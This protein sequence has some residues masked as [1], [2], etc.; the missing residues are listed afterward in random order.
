[1][2]NMMATVVVCDG[3]T[4]SLVISKALRKADSFVVLSLSKYETA[5]FEVIKFCNHEIF[6]KLNKNI[7]KIILVLKWIFLAFKHTFLALKRIFL[8]L[9]LLFLAFKNMF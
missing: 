4:K 7:H 1:M 6:T 8:A 9:K 3:R 2:K 5:S